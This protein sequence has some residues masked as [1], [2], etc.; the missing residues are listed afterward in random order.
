MRHLTL[1]LLLGTVLSLTIGCQKKEEPATQPTPEAKDPPAAETTPAKE[2]PP[3]GHPAIT[4]ANKVLAAIH[5]DD[6]AAIRPLLNAGN[7]D[8]VGKLTDEELL[9]LLSEFK[10]EIGDV[11]EVTEV[12]KGRREN[13][14][15]A[16]IRVVGD[17]VFVVVLTLEEGQYLFE[18]LNSPN[19]AGYE[20]L[21][22]IAP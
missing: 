22:K 2:E 10:E 12:K 7:R 15:A 13:Q 4:A 5:A 6:A 1:S 18:D 14:V 16:K 21:E 17:E 19:V 3:A 8:E 20:A 11:T 9:K